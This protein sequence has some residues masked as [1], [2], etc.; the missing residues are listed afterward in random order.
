MTFTI[1]S[2]VFG[3]LLFFTCCSWVMSLKKFAE[4][5][6]ITE[7]ELWEKLGK[8]KMDNFYNLTTQ[9]LREYIWKREYL[10]LEDADLIRVGKE[11]RFYHVICALSGTF[12]LMCYVMPFLLR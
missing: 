2:G 4:R 11:A 5:L 3:T 7:S 10:N 1:L 6:E 9:E 12:L 8:P